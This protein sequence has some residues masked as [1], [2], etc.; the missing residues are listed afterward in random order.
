MATLSRV[1][2]LFR[3]L[4]FMHFFDRNVIMVIETVIYQFAK[5]PEDGS[6]DVFIPNDS[7]LLN[8]KYHVFAVE[9]KPYHDGIH[10]KA[11]YIDLENGNDY[12]ICLTFHNNLQYF[13]N[14]TDDTIV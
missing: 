11:I 10:S 1:V 7:L 8:L 4:S 13:I 12:Q 9:N 6:L 5:N 3:F 2:Y 14:C